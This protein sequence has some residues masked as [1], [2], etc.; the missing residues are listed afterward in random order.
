MY[1]ILAKVFALR[2]RK[3]IGKVMGPSQHAFVPR[4]Q[5]L[6]AA[7]IANECIDS[8]IRSG[9]SGILHKLDIEKIYDNVSWSFFWLSLKKWAFLTSGGNGS[10]FVFPLCAFLS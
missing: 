3:V 5:I 10:L 9:I 7:L 6:D 8:Y 4:C 2:L 1:K